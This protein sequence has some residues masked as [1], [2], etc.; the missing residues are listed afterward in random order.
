V[1]TY[2]YDSY[3]IIAYFEGNVRYR[4]YFESATGITTF[5]NALEVYYA[6]LRKYGREA[7]E[8]ILMAL[9][10]WVITPTMSDVA[11]SMKFR[12]QNKKAKLSYI[13][14]LGYEI[15]KRESCKFLTG[16]KEFK[17]MKNVEFVQV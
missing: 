1:T 2:F 17:N 14:C 5:Y 15:A 7:A 16:D 8:E 6:Y 4:K 13:D 3:A 11:P 9:T 12:L 10:E